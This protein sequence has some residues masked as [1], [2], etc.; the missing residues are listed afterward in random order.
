MPKT[1]KD[2]SLRCF[3]TS[4]HFCQR[5]GLLYSNI[6]YGRKA[7]EIRVRTCQFSKLI[8]CISVFMFT[9]SFFHYFHYIS[10]NQHL[11]TSVRLNSV[12]VNIFS[13][14]DLFQTFSVQTFSDAI[15]NILLFKIEK[16]Y[17]IPQ[18]KGQSSI[19]FGHFSLKKSINLNE[20]DF[21]RC[22]FKVP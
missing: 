9:I 6:A 22:Y 20:F 17:R 18:E 4:R 7:A 8:R 3:H 19:F 11:S 12:F 21:H 13:T 2:K 16:S 14:T 5:I 15:V 1:E 10:T